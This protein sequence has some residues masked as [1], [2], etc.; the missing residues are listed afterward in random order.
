[1]KNKNFLI[2]GGGGPS[3]E[4]LQNLWGHENT[5]YFAD[6]D[7]NKIGPFIALDKKLQIPW[8]DSDKFKSELIKIIN[9]YKIDIVISQV[10][11]ELIAISQIEKELN[12]CTFIIPNSKFIEI[13]LDKYIS[14]TL[15]QEKLQADPNTKLFNINYLADSTDSIIKPSH[16]R[17]SR[18][19]FFGKN[20]E[21]LE[22]LKQY[23]AFSTTIFV[24]QDRIEGDEY[25]VQVINNQKSDIKA[26]VP[27]KIY[28]KKGSTTHG[29]V[30]N[31]SSVIKFCEK[32]NE[33]FPTKG[34][35]NIQ[36]ILEK[37]TNRIFVFEV[38][39]RVSTTM[40][41]A[42]YAGLDPSKMYFDLGAEEQLK[43]AQDGI[44]IERFWN[45][46]FS[47]PNAK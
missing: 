33:V 40:C 41:V 46:V 37:N 12:S 42:I 4:A 11:E 7:I 5:L 9:E 20:K 30:E 43:L 22:A 24:R 13:F 32:F 1:M 19:L 16:G 14:G 44:T 2:T 25:S 27:I 35:Y 36:L 18:D 38:N 8:A 29:V 45:N 26:V 15:I 47:R 31:N 39:P 6:A 34:T 17:G 10:D 3:T 28:E 21:E 23:L